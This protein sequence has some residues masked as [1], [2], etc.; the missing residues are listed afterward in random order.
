MFKQSESV[1]HFT[2]KVLG[3]YF[4][5]GLDVASYCTSDQVAEIVDLVTDSITNGETQMKESSINKYDTRQKLRRYVAG[6]VKNW[7]D[8]SKELNGG[9]THTAKSPG[10]R[11]YQKDE[12]I[13]NLKIMLKVLKSNGNHEGVAEVQ[14]AIDNRIAELKSEFNPLVNSMASGE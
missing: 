10:T 12:V 1:V 4:Q 9:I 2:K 3:S 11:K 6:M 7:F 13:K 14:E 8:K 5:P